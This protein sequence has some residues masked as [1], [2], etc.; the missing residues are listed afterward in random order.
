MTAI[1]CWQIDAFTQ[2]PFSGNPAAICWIDCDAPIEWMQAV[3]NEMNLSET[4]FVR[5]Q[6]DDYSLRWFTPEVEVSLCGHAT[7]ASAHALWTADLHSRKEP[8]RFHTQSGVLTCRLTDETIE[9]DFPSKPS[10]NAEPPEGLLEALGLE[11]VVEVRK[12]GMDHL[13][14]VNRAETVRSLKPDFGKL[15]SIPT[16]GTIVTSESDDD[17]Y[18]FVSRFFAPAVG[19]DEDP[20]TGSAHCCL[21]PYWAAELGK[22]ELVAL[23]ASR[24]KGVVQ[25][26]VADNRVI[27]GGQAVTVWRGELEAVPC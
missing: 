26:R 2:V 9:M 25:V 23:Q 24:R 6:A 20:V 21:G 8:I 27:L 12:N 1:P 14:V 17:S 3:A 18:D 19:I 5:R 4:A 16:R 7:L 11:S 13:I 10:L 15:K 22:R